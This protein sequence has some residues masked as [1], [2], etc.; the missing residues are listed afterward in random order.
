MMDMKCNQAGCENKAA[1][2]F[3]WPG[4]DEAGI[5]EQHSTKLR[6]VAHA[7]GMHVQLIPL[8]AA[9]EED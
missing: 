6:G 7:M 2:R 1:Y 9:K 4:R 8:S 3:T 5:C